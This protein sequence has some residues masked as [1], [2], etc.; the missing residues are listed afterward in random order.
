M[1]TQQLEQ[2]KTEKPMSALSKAIVTGF[3]GGVLWSFI[4]T[5]TYYFSF[6]TVSAASF[7]I[8]SWIQTEWASSWLGELL[9]ILC[10][11]VLSIVVAV[12]YFFLFRKMVGMMPAMIFGVALWF[13]FFYFMNPVFEA[14]PSFSELDSNTIVTT[15]CIYLLYGTFIGYSISYEYQQYEAENAK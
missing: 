13:V 10:V 15:I 4:G 6:S 8:R 2:N 7:V 9:G 5:V 3:V 11:G 1:E 12:L 14:V